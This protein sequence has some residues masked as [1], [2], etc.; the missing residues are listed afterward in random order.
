MCAVPLFG[1]V[2]LEGPNLF[3]LLK[4]CESMGDSI[5]Q[6]TRNTDSFFPRFSCH[7]MIFPWL[8]FFIA[9]FHYSLLFSFGPA[10]S[11]SYSCFALAWCHF[12]NLRKSWIFYNKILFA[13]V[14]GDGARVVAF[15]RGSF[16]M[17]SS[18]WSG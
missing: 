4:F 17:V 13:R 14:F 3:A 8:R 11:Y 9:V 6:S 10:A 16:I 1:Y 12:G 15:I 5:W 2:L 18:T 7:L